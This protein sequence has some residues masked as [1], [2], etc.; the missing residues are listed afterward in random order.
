M[1]E[2]LHNTV[3]I[4][5]FLSIKIRSTKVDQYVC[6]LT[7]AYIKLLHILNTSFGEYKEDMKYPLIMARRIRIIYT[8]DCLKSS[9]QNSEKITEYEDTLKT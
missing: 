4:Q 6:W 2:Y 3:I 1:L 7:Q 9:V 8:G 5:Y